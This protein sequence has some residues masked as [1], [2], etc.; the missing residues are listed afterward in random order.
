MDW[1]TQW[2]LINTQILVGY[3][4]S[5]Q[6]RG[7]SASPGLYSGTQTDQGKSN[8][9]AH[10]PFLLLLRLY[11]LVLTLTLCSPSQGQKFKRQC[12]YLSLLK[13]LV[14]LSWDNSTSKV[15]LSFP[16]FTLPS[17]HRPHLGKHHNLPESCK[18]LQTNVTVPTHISLPTICSTLPL[19]LSFQNMNPLINF[20]L[21]I[22]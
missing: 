19:E 21:K 10:F 18:C 5:S 20:L 4:M 2:L 22:L 11:L 12:K 17:M 16:T 6:P 7:S 3:I 14:H 9:H 13:P 15:S 1:S 8:C